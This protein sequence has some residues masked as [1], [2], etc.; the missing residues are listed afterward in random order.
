MAIQNTCWMGTRFGSDTG[1]HR[2]GWLGSGHPIVG[3]GSC[4]LFFEW[5]ARMSLVRNPFFLA[6]WFYPAYRQKCSTDWRA[7]GNLGLNP[8]GVGETLLLGDKASKKAL[9]FLPAQAW[10]MP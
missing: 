10:T 7:R 4:V 8:S 5:K 3:D 1:K 2:S 9:V 6:S